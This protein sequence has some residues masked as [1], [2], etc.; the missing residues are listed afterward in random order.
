MGDARL[1]LEKKELKD[2]EKYGLIVVDAFSSDAIPIHLITLEALDDFL[3]KLTDDGVLCFHISNRYLDLKPVL[4]NLARERDWRRSIRTT[5]AT[6]ITLRPP[7][8]A[9]PVR[10]G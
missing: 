3:A 5:S 9:K 2:S 8:S 4:Y 7:C 1:T 10:L 6:T